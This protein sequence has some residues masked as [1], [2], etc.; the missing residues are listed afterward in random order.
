M[1]ERA[2]AI[3]RRY[4]K[5][6]SICMLIDVDMRDMKWH[7]FKE[8]YTPE[9]DSYI[10]ESCLNGIKDIRKKCHQQMDTPHAK[11]FEHFL[12]WFA[13]DVPGLVDVFSKET[14]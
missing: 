7:I 12:P 4:Q 1:T 11:I 8:G 10:C 2:H 14:F 5:Q 6:C 13:K 9:A 3:E